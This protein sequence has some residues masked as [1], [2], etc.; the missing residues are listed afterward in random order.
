MCKEKPEEWVFTIKQDGLKVA[1][2]FAFNK[3][4]CLSE[5]CHY[6][7]QYEEEDFTKMTMEVKKK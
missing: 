5:A 7:A 4:D 6:W 2:G 1:G 3:E